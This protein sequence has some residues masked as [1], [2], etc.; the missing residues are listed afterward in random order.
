[1][2]P[3]VIFTDLDGTLLDPVTYTW[4]TAKPALDFLDSQGIPLVFVT[5]KTRAEVEV[6]RRS[7]KNTHPFVVENGGAAFVPQG[8]FP[9]DV[10]Q[11]IQRDNL[12]VLEWGKPYCELV[13]GLQN[14]SKISGCKVRGFHDMSSHEVAQ[15]CGLS[16]DEAALAKTREY[17]EPF[18]IQDAALAPSLLTA[19]ERA[20]LRWTRGGRFYHVCGN[21]DKAQAVIQLL[22][23]YGRIYPTVRSIGLGDGLNDVDFLRVV[24]EP[25][26]LRSPFLDQLRSQVPNCYVP[27]AYGPAGWNEAVFA[28][29]KRRYDTAEAL[30]L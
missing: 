19:L 8:Y 21:N 15:S 10:A 3:T 13:S 16:I 22:S 24:D 26:V 20:G 17:D 28:L 27:R 12:H 23:L 25:V 6:L 11:S 14:A 9:F 4:E 1:M 2:S 5:S 29:L 18:D 30:D 7:L